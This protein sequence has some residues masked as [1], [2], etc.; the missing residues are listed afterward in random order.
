MIAIDRLFFAIG[1]FRT[2]PKS[3]SF[4]S[5]SVDT[6]MLLAFRSRWTIRLRWGAGNGVAQSAEGFEHGCEIQP[7]VGA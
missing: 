2:I 6:K 5:G 7:M 1:D 4:G 3:S